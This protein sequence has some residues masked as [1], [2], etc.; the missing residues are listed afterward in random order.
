[1]LPTSIL[2]ILSAQTMTSMWR[3]ITPAQY[4]HWSV[5]SPHHHSSVLCAAD[6]FAR[7]SGQPLPVAQPMLGNIPQQ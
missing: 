3:V 5:A 2:S 4:A 7:A 6:V 1:M